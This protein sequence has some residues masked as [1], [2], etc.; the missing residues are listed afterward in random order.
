MLGGGEALS[1]EVEV[2]KMVVFGC[3]VMMTWNAVYIMCLIGDFWASDVGICTL[4][5]WFVGISR[6]D[7]RMLDFWLR[8]AF[9]N[10][11]VLLYHYFLASLRALLML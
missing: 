11:T 4:E 9:P 6:M 10:K 8:K 3:W 2:M 1:V 7:W 5:E